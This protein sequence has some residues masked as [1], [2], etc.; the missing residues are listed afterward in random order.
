MGLIF[1]ESI[2]NLP[3]EVFQ[4]LVGF[5]E[6]F[7]ALVQVLDPLTD[8][9]LQNMEMSIRRLKSIC[10]WD[11]KD[12]M[13]LMEESRVA[14]ARWEKVNEKFLNP[15]S[16]QRLRSLVLEIL[17]NFQSLFFQPFEE[18]MEKFGD[19]LAVTIPDDELYVADVSAKV[20][21][22]VAKFKE[23]EMIDAALK[24]SE[25]APKQA[26]QEIIVKEYF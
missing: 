20:S 14:T 25:F 19:H 24:I 13:S 18:F 15:E 22:L 4:E 9:F 6:G 8:K 23:H 5:I 11:K 16:R 26:A 2:G 10:H 17:S 12:I 21:F 1:G 7:D 3:E